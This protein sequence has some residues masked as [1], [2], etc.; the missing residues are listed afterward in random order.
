[1]AQEALRQSEEDLRAVFDNVDQAV[2]LL[3]P[4]GRVQSF[5][6]RAQ[7]SF[8]KATDKELVRGK[9]FADYI[10]PS[11]MG[12]YEASFKS[13]REGQRVFRERAYLSPDGVEHWFEFAYNPVLGPGGKVA[14][15]CFVSQQ[16]DERKKA[17]QDLRRS[18]AE[19][20]T[21]F[22]S[23][24]Q[25]MVLIRS[26]GSIQDFN[27]FAATMAQRVQGKTLR[28]GMKFVETLPQGAS[29][30]KY[31]E[32]FQAALEGKET[33]AERSIRDGQGQERWVELRYQP[34]LNPSGGVEA[35]VFSLS[36]IDER[37]RAEEALRE[38]Q[39]RFERFAM[40]TH[41][42]ILMHENPK[43]VDANPALADMLGYKVEE[44]IGRP[45]FDFI[46][47]ESHPVA[48][49]HMVTGSPQ[50]YE[51]LA[52][53]KDGSVFP[54]ELRGETFTYKGRTLRVM[55]VRDLTWH[56]AA[57]RILTES[58]ERYRRLVELAPDAV[59]VHSSGQILYVNPAGLSLFGGEG[60]DLRE[61]NLADF[62][63]PDTREAVLER[64]QRIQET[65]QPSEWMEQKLIRLDGEEFVGETKGTPFLF[66]G[67]PAVLTIVRDVTERRKSQQTLLR[68]ER[69]AAVGKVIA[70]IAH[71]VRNP[72]AVL[73]GMIQLL[74]AKMEGRKEYSQELKTILSQAERL[75]FFMNDILDYSKE[76]EIKRD[77]VDVGELLEESL[78]ATQAQVG[79]RADRIEV[80]LSH[81]K[82][83]APVQVD[84]DRLEQVLVNLLTNAYQAVGE[85]GKL[86]VGVKQT[87]TDTRWIVEDDGPGIPDADLNH[88]FEPFFTTKKG[89]SGL[90]LPISQKI[91]EAHGGKIEVERLRPHGTRFTV[92]IPTI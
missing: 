58:E 45:G 8:R 47:P 80:E 74:N 23:G 29:E 17:E 7:E 30:E 56:K 41:E 28:K 13:A 14:G 32:S 6:P 79:P 5:N 37:K 87:K 81:A 89:G 73:S 91:V 53:R 86:K 20:R 35:V 66:K 4:E 67:I 16:I 38:S 55:S 26:D 49:E 22:N 48:R 2:V 84:R 69:L 65:N 62:L 18:E 27:Q 34:A 31:H 59:V 46:S 85:K 36:F 43:V 42:G 44:M 52:L 50:P 12:L 19:L 10:R 3:T 25:V 70:A 63:H 39:E 88:L 82:K 9:F 72:L 68:Y 64:V 1:M 78:T 51:V 54:V 24:S 75:R 83:A 92:V 40:V 77:A 21:V 71:E 11:D 57:E 60:R 76:L 33:R 90:G 61:F 15:V